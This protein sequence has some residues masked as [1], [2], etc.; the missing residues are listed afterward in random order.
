MG[1]GR[2]ARI[3]IA[4]GITGLVWLGACIEVEEFHY[5]ASGSADAATDAKD[6]ASDSQLTLDGAS[7]AC[8]TAGGRCMR[9]APVGWDGPFALYDGAPSNAPTCKGTPLVDAK[10]D[11]SS[12]PAAQC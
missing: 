2:G 11:L 9:P 10:A 6:A 12:V 7:G 8:A 4:A 1:L 5:H 3:P